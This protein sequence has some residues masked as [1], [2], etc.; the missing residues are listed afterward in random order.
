MENKSWND[1]RLQIHWNE[2]KWVD[3]RSRI[4]KKSLFL[5]FLLKQIV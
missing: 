3:P 1:W 4:E 2:L 5:V